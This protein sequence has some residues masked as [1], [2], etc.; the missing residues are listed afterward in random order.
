VRVGAAGLVLGVLVARTGSGPFVEGVRLT[1]AW[2]LLAGAV[3]TAATTACSAWRWRLV[4]SALGVRLT[5]GAAVLAIYRSQFLNAT[6]PGGVLGDVDRAVGHGRDTG[7]LG[8]SVRSVVWERALGQVVQ[9]ALTVAVLVVLPSPMRT[10]GIV[11]MVGLAGCAGALLLVRLVVGTTPAVGRAARALATDLRAVLGSPGNRRGIGLASAGAVAGHV[12]VFL[13]AARAAGVAGSPYRLVPLAAVVLL[14]AAVPANI[15]GW[16][17]REGV[18]A[19]AFAAAGLGATTGV[20]VAVVYG[21][22]SLVA[23]LPGAVVLVAGGRLAS[24]A[25]AHAALPDLGGRRR[26]EPVR[27]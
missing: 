26:E 7:A 22:I 4:A 10:V 27:A 2:A 3:V 15:A 24:T 11:G 16:G 23:T 21:V 14:A 9:V 17:P 20:T 25:P 13:V 12:L 1:T 8:R 19:W 6:L 18:A 5:W